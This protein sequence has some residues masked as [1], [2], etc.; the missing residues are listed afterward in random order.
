MRLHRERGLPLVICRPGIVIGEGC[1][2]AHWGV[3]MFHSDT[4]VQFWGDGSNKLPLVLVDDVA[5]GLV[6]SGEVPGIEGQAFLLTDAPLLSA[7]E[8]VEAVSA[9]SK[10]RIRAGS[11]ALWRFFLLD[12]AKELVK[13]IIRHPNRKRPSYHDWACRRHGSIYDSRRTREVLGWLPAGSR[14][15]LLECGVRASVRHYMK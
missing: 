11:H 3:G 15:A 1:P 10:V 14:E 2:P 12:C 8:Y 7:R 13:H 6:L 5:A 9:H 4:R